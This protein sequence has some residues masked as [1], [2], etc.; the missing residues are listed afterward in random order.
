MKAFEPLLNPKEIAAVLGI[1]GKTVIR[2]AR[3]G[4]IPALRVDKQL[5]LPTIRARR[6]IIVFV[7]VFVFAGTLTI[8]HARQ[9]VTRP[10]IQLSAL[11]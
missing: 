3:G 11:F 7:F 6:V 8:H 10:D 1:H 4:K 2:L 9:G 5:A